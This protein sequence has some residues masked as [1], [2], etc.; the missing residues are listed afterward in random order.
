MSRIARPDEINY[1][2]DDFHILN[3][4]LWMN[5]GFAYF[6]DDRSAMNANTKR[7]PSY[8]PLYIL[9]QEC[10]NDPQKC[11]LSQPHM[12]ITDNSLG[13]TAVALSEDDQLLAVAFAATS[14]GEIRIYDLQT[15]AVINRISLPTN[16]QDPNWGQVRSMIWGS[17]P[18]QI[19]LS[20]NSTRR[21]YSIPDYRRNEL[22]LLFDCSTTKVYN[23]S[24]LS[25]VII[26]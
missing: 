20:M 19:I 4:P 2:P 16:E 24:I 21:I 13:I 1:L 18:N 8:H 22:E 7:Y 9:S 14:K 12:V 25:K 15:F 26:K 5:N 23:C 17:Q 11:D 6:I 3:F 10:I